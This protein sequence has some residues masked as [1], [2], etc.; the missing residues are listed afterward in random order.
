MADLA[1]TLV[2]PS[3]RLV[4]SLGAQGVSEPGV[5]GQRC[6]TESEWLASRRSKRSWAWP[7]CG[8]VRGGRIVAVFSWRA[9]MWPA[10]R[11]QP[12]RCELAC[13]DAHSTSNFP[14]LG[15]PGIECSVSSSGSCGNL[16]DACLVRT[17]SSGSAHGTGNNQVVMKLVR[18][19]AWRLAV[20]IAALT[21]E[22]GAETPNFTL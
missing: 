16:L 1:H 8:V 4:K 12:L 19:M 17:P 6:V 9:W 22:G 18:Q 7:A 11:D 21:V 2:F 13:C 10:I 5:N 3:L 15:P 14:F 20:F